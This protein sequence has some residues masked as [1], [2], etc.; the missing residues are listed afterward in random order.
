MTT[1]ENIEEK[2]QNID[3]SNNSKVQNLLLLKLLNRRKTR[4]S[5]S[6]EDLDA[7]VAAG[8]GFPS[9]MDSDGS[10]KK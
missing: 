3:F 9:K 7:V 6:L 5:L 4:S 1:E 10:I 8:N 2:L